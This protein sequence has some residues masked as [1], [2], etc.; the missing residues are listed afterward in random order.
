MNRAPVLALLVLA[1]AIGLRA[2]GLASW[3]LDGDELHSY[4][5]VRD[6]LEGAPWPDGVRGYPVGYM[7]MA[8]SARL[9]G[10]DELGL[11]LPAALCGVL[12]VA[13]LLVLR[14]DALSRR[15][16][17]C[18][19]TLAALSPWLVYHAQTARFYAPLL[20]FATLATL[21]ALPGPRRRPWTAALC[22]L[23]AV[24]C[25]P[26]ALLLGP[27]LAAPVLLSP[28]ATRRVLAGAVLLT[29]GGLVSWLVA[30]P[31]LLAVAERAF[32]GVDPG[33]YD[34]THF[35]L[36]LG[37]NLGPCVGLLVLGGLLALRRVEAALRLQLVAASLLPTA[38]LLAAALSG[39]SMHQRYAMGSV[40]ALLLVAGCGIDRLAE[41]RPRLALAALLLALVAR[42]PDLGGLWLDGDRH[43][44]RA[45]AS[46]LAARAAPDDAFVADEHATLGLYLH[47]LPGFADTDIREAPI[48]ESKPLH[49]IPRQ[50]KTCWLALKLSRLDGSYGQEFM[51]W[52]ADH[53]TEV[54]RIGRAP[55]PLARHDNR[56]VL[57]ARTRRLPL[58]APEDGDR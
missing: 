11:R 10:L 29:L 15:T 13:A 41:R 51:D 5:D 8:G 3:S 44:V 20:L 57:Y 17:L 42:L 23:L 34:L 14:R 6:V 56:T 48:V 2:H 43:D 47:R 32:A 19:G 27:A 4:Y 33:H 45:V 40:P 53:F 39:L 7:L 28:L 25:H 49:D 9:F 30:G 55:L 52:V 18:A 21:F 58:D 26:T 12:A 22:W 46:A 38:V 24:G 1:A 36:G 37:Y 50:R 16:S 35:V 54:A 31:A